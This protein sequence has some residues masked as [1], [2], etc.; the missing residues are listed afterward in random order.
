MAEG[1][2]QLA[3]MLPPNAFERS[4]TDRANTIGA[5]FWCVVG[6]RESYTR[7][8][9]NGEWAGFDCSLSGRDISD[10]GKVV[11]ALTESE[12]AFDDILPGIDWTPVRDELLL[13]LLEH[14]AQHQGQ[15][16]RFIYG[17]GYR[18]PDWW[19]RRWALDS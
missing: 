2:R 9:E 8:I 1:H 7:A 15:L 17:L 6:A 3:E 12:R 10:Q 11:A 18:F 14:E 19:A 4:L 13:D 16:I 5:Q